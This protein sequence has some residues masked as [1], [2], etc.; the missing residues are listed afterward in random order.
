MA[1]VKQLSPDGV[2]RPQLKSLDDLFGLDEATAGRAVVELDFD[3]LVPY[4]DHK[5]SLYEGERLADM[6]ESVRNN[7]V[8]TPILVHM[9]GE[10]YEILAGHN[11]ANAAKLAGLTTVPAIILD[12]LSDK[13]AQ[14]VV[15]ET[16][17][18]QRSFG[19]MKHSEKAAVLA[20][21]HAKMFSQGKRNDILSHT[22]EI[23]DE[24][25]RTCAI[26]ST[27]YE[28]LKTEYG[29]SK[30]TVARYL[31][32]DKMINDLKKLLDDGKISFL[33]AVQLSYLRLPEQTL[34]AM[35]L[36]ADNCNYTLDMKKSERLRKQ[37][38][39]EKMNADDI[40]SILEG[41]KSSKPPKRKPI[42]K[43]NENLYAHYFADKTES[44]IKAIVH[45][46]IC[47]YFERQGDAN[48]DEN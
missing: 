14:A 2:S 10:K 19:D 6:V 28:I 30:D 26:K 43:L 25:N 5:F 1:K 23:D 15:V 3:D 16:N 22:D 7:G 21:H 4:R 11:R 38:E 20:L 46:A 37:S 40:H 32:V 24:L 47:E 48:H 33:S 13:E 12:T 27:T 34:V 39:I 9:W 44:E 17:L 8:F 36:T 41:E 42:V 31:R 35:C 18:M 45:I 29:L